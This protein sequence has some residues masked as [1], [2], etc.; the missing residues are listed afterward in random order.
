LYR[1]KSQIGNHLLTYYELQ[2]VIELRYSKI[3]GCEKTKLVESEEGKQRIYFTEAH[4]RRR[5]VAHFSDLR[6]LRGHYGSPTYNVMESTIE[7]FVELQVS[8]DV[9]ITYKQGDYVKFQGVKHKVLDV[10]VIAG[11]G[12]TMYKLDH[13]TVEDATISNFSPLFHQE[14]THPEQIRPYTDDDLKADVLRMYRMVLKHFHLLFPLNTSPDNFVLLH[15][16]GTIPA[17]A[18]DFTHAFMSMLNAKNIAEFKLAVNSKLIQRAIQIHFTKQTHE[19]LG[20]KN[21]RDVFHALGLM[22]AAT[23]IERRWDLFADPEKE[24]SGKKIC[25]GIDE[26]FKEIKATFKWKKAGWELGINKSVFEVETEDKFFQNHCGL[27]HYDRLR[28]R[29]DASEAEIHKAWTAM[30]LKIHPDKT[31]ADSSKEMTALNKAH[32]ILMDHATRKEYSKWWIANGYS[33]NP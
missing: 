18:Q 25:E 15:H 17:I 14:Y 7:Q 19:R 24:S 8:Y 27:S 30:A 3:Q 11:A 5:Q 4:D 6:R 1:I 28:V 12:L 31:R 23:V 16:A 26:A 10:K 22:T 9:S 32:E 29:R 21:F 13:A 33:L 20:A 2:P